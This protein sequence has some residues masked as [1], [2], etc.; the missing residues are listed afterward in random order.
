[1]RMHHHIRIIGAIVTGAALVASPAIM[2]LPAASAS[3]ASTAAAPASAPAQGDFA[4][5]K[6][7]AQ[8]EGAVRVIVEVK[9]ETTARTNE[10]ARI[11]TAQDSVEAQ[12]GTTADV[13]Q[14]LIR[15]PVM[16]VDATPDAIDT[17]RASRTVVSVTRDEANTVDLSTSTGFVQATTLWASGIT[18]T[19]TNVAIL[20]TGVDTSHPMLTGKITA[21]ACFTFFACPNGQSNQFGGGAATPIASHGTHVASTAAG[22]AW[23]AP[24]GTQIQG[25]APGAGVIAVQVFQL[26]SGSALAYDSS[27]LAAL[28]WLIQ[29]RATTPIASANM[30]LG[31]GLF[32]SQE[33]CDFL[34]AN[35]VSAFS[36]ARNVG[37]APVVAAGNSNATGSLS[38]PGCASGAVSVGA[39]GNDALNEIANYSNVAPWLTLFAPGGCG[40]TTGRGIYAA[41]PNA[42]AASYCGTSMAT[43][44][45]AGAFALMR[46]QLPNATVN[47]LVG[48]LQSTG[49]PVPSARNTTGVRAI[50]I[51]D[52][53][54]VS[55]A[56]TTTTTTTT[57]P[58]PTTTTAA[59]TTTT[60]AP[61]TTTTTAPA[62]APA[63]PRRSQRR[64]GYRLIG[65]DGAI[66]P[67]GDT[68]TTARSATLAPG[69]GIVAAA[70]AGTNGS[71]LA[72]ANGAVYTVGDAPALGDMRGAPLNGSIVGMAATPS[73]NGYWLLGSD[74]GIFGFGDATFHG[75]AGNIRLNEP[76]VG[77]AAAPNGDGYLLVARDGGI[78]GYG[79]GAA[80]YGSAGNIRLNQP[81]VGMAAAP[82]GNGYW[83]V[84]SDGGIFG[85]GPGATFYGSAGDR[86]LAAPIVGMN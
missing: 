29:L 10:G 20:D 28:D 60:T 27:I 61:P 75:S 79:P 13:D 78:F 83:L 44:H 86:S 73:G 49:A 62:P 46:Q 15:I 56:P 35:Y 17:L 64:P 55:P 6:D 85:Y 32:P 47:E 52:A 38:A 16:T 63:P 40:P 66:F 2:L 3:A 31:G 74:G 58:A 9:P 72:A 69:A 45:V 50:R 26:V 1:M 24:N 57:A 12:L 19:G 67:Y 7:E 84:A 48:R 70:T 54:G 33:S 37:I 8:R 51:A 81:I 21:E 76:I 4:A 22:R 34:R 77:M 71:W 43:P 36:R 82:N 30:S 65:G 42:S 80:F 11:R 39:V 41:I 59:P 68:A 14:K 53:L 5:L 18:G 23:T 25:V